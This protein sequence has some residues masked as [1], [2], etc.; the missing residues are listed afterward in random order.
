MLI[1][2]LLHLHPFP[3]CPTLHSCNNPDSSSPFLC[4]TQLFSP[5]EHPHS[6]WLFGHCV[7]PFASKA[8]CVPAEAPSTASNKPRKPRKFQQEPPAQELGS[9]KR[10]PWSLQPGYFRIQCSD[11]IKYMN[12]YRSRTGPGLPPSQGGLRLPVAL[13]VLS[14]P[15]GSRA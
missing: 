9:L 11:S 15:Q 1:C 6:C 7:H 10:P 14:S 3:P 13:G 2:F 12:H 8:P 4:E 5:C